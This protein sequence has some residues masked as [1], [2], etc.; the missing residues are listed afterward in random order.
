MLRV[1]PSDQI[2]IK[3]MNQ[4]SINFRRHPH[5]LTPCWSQETHPCSLSCFECK[6]RLR[7][8]SKGTANNRAQETHR[9]S[10]HANLGAQE[11]HASQRQNSKHVISCQGQS[12]SATDSEICNARY[13]GTHTPVWLRCTATWGHRGPPSQPASSTGTSGPACRPEPDAAAQC[14]VPR[15]GSLSAGVAATT[16]LL[17]LSRPLGAGAHSP[18]IE[19]TSCTAAAAPMQTCTTTPLRHAILSNLESGGY[20]LLTSP[21]SLQACGARAASA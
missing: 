2:V 12:G 10:V 11:A 4:A 21:L 9:C 17:Q 1:T 19:A 16:A 20:Q 5:S 8:A 6:K 18:Y 14:V 15:T 7:R 3:L 13:Q